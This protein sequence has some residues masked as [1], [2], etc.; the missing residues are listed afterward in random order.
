MI[1]KIKDFLKNRFSRKGTNDLSDQDF[2]EEILDE[3]SSREISEQSTDEEEV[4]SEYVTYEAAEKGSASPS[5]KE[6]LT[7]TF[8]NIKIPNLKSKNASA[9]P[10]AAAAVGTSLSPSIS[11]LSEKFL[12][13][14]SREAIHQIALVLMVC[15][16]TYTLGKF[17]ALFLKGNP[18]VDSPK[19]FSVVIPFE[20]EFNPNTLTQVKTIN[21]FRTNTGL[22]GKKKMADTKCDEATQNT[23]LPLKLINT[24]VL[25]DSVKSLASVQVRGARDLQEV[26]VGDQIDNLAKIFK[27]YR[28]Q[29]VVKNLESGVCESVSSDQ[30]RSERPSPVS[31]MSPTQKKD[32]LANKKMSGIE[33]QGNKFTIQKKLLDDKLKDLGQILSQAKAIPIQNPDG[34]LSFKMTEMDPEGIFPYLGLQDQDI[35]TSIN[36]KP[37]YD[38]NEVMSLFARIKNLENLQ[39][40][41]KREGSDSVQEYTIKK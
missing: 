1:N 32:Y 14:G 40:G 29:L 30:A 17:S 8:R 21:I 2:E 3:D 36:G 16:I 4:P 39:L 33:N 18:A 6:R 26:R 12:S 9:A 25:Q 20:R 19:R 41:V 34:T 24:I 31:V 28:F 38:M 11:R 5:L 7:Q 23:S 10:V 27:I 15:G 35:I 13:R 37:I 22:T